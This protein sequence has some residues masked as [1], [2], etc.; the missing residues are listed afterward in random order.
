[1]NQEPTQGGSNGYLVFN[2]T[3]SYT[4]GSAVTDETKLYLPGHTI[5]TGRTYYIDGFSQDIGPVNALE[6]REE[7]SLDQSNY[8]TSSPLDIRTK[9][10]SIGYQT[11]VSKTSSSFSNTEG[12]DISFIIEGELI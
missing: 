12:V 2:E 4:S 10:L 8:I 3:S 9:G 6:D 1:M 5:G 7:T 11:E